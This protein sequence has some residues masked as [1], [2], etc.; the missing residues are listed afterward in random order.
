MNKLVV[1]SIAAFTL[2]GCQ[3]N[4]SSIETNKP[5]VIII[6][7]DD[8]GYGDVGCY[9]AKGVKTPNIDALAKG[10]MR[11]TDA[12]CGAATCTPS[13]YSLLTGEY[14]FR[15]NAAVLA[16][17]AP[18]LIDTEKKTMPDM[19]K[20][21][22]YTTAVIGKWHL[23]LGDGELNWNDSIKPGPREIGFDYSF[24]I[25]AT[26]DR[27]PSVYV[28]DYNI[29]GLDP[30]D[31]VQ[32]SYTTKVG[33]WPTGTENP[34]M[35]KQ[36]ADLQHSGT[37]TN[38]VS[39]I[40]FMSGGEKAL[41]KD[42]DF[43]FVLN[44]KAK[45]FIHA[46]KEN[47]FFLYYAYHDIHVPR[48]P[49]EKFVGA[50]VMGPRGDA[51][52]QMD[53]CTGEIVKYLKE[54]GIDKNTLI[55]FSSDNGPVLD[56]G[57]AD[58]CVEMLGEHKPSGIYRGGKYSAFEAGTRVPTIVYWPGSVSPGE[59]NALLSQVDLYAS[60]AELVEQPLQPNDAIDSKS[61]L[62]A[63]LGL[64][65]KGREVILE[66]SYVKSL[67]VGDWKYIEPSNASSD[68]IENDKKIE[69]GI[70]KKAQ[71]YN[72]A[73]DPSEQVNVIEENKDQAVEMDKLLKEIVKR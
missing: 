14:A 24:L 13:R 23:G 73:S 4:N 47:P 54:L 22:G 9:G 43:P 66:E 39:R 38:G 50:S 20:N 62:S 8:L 57:Y 65:D 33:D 32:V 1:L 45:A 31:P 26:G 42:E 46:N 30:N 35:L 18:L 15:I 64:S 71:L 48:I 34:E 17:D 67:R 56:D 63:W 16:G 5:N 2:L 19:F 40:G 28:E 51:I 11:F 72:L 36:Q 3:S 44:E 7:V 61:T 49:N 59:S 29:V 70:S 52:A 12:H 55:I 41:W 10:G 68:W 58:E 25:P 53:W 69:S 60:L 27:V 37:I 21:A 6:Y